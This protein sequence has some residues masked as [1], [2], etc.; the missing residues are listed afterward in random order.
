MHEDFLRDFKFSLG[1]RGRFD[2]NALNKAIPNAYK[3]V[4]AR[5][6]EDKKGIDYKTI[7][8]NGTIINI[9]AKARRKGAK[10]D[11]VDGEPVLAI[12]IWS[13]RPTMGN[14]PE[15]GW[16]LKTSVDTD[17]VL[18]TFDKD[19]FNGFYLLPFQHL[20]MATLRNGRNWYGK[21][22]HSVQPNPK[23][24][25]RY[26]SE[27]MFVPASVVIKAVADEMQFEIGK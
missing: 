2:I 22:K 4:K 12:E 5:K 26:E 20:R 18:Y 16:T 15:V 25:P 14:K 24:N 9:D 27:C 21:Y 6:E 7:L 19:D 8:D 10:R 23:D 3:T 13:V 1:E 17:M 11:F